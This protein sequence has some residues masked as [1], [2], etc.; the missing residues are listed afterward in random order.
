[1]PCDPISCTLLGLYIGVPGALAYGGVRYMSR[2]HFKSQLVQSIA[3]A[4]T[5]GLDELDPLP[6][7][8]F[9]KFE[10]PRFTFVR[11]RLQRAHNARDAVLF[12]S[13]HP[14]AK[15]VQSYLKVQKSMGLVD[16][17]VLYLLDPALLI[18]SEEQGR[19]LLMST[20]TTG[21]TDGTY[22]ESIRFVAEY[23]ELVGDEVFQA[24]LENFQTQNKISKEPWYFGRASYEALACN[25]ESGF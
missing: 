24:R 22:K 2:R 8:T 20:D 25:Q 10:I 11:Q 6:K 23:R 5:S 18:F 21:C 19:A 9:D 4:V 7:E 12:D 3:D 14:R 15:D 17:R 1:M 13:A 16:P